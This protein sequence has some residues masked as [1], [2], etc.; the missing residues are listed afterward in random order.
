MEIR[1][2]SCSNSPA[3]SRC[4]QILY[5]WQGRWSKTFI[6][7]RIKVLCGVFL[8]DFDMHKYL[9]LILR[10]H[11]LKLKT[12]N[13][14]CPLDPGLICSQ[15]DST[16]Y[17]AVVTWDKATFLCHVWSCLCPQDTWIA[18]HS[19]DHVNYCRFTLNWT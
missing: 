12:H 16:L 10:W 14:S 6:P 2:Q 18:V 7:P 17:V 9:T 4:K 3:S 19:A 5:P 8:G 15:L 1:C 13:C 11:F